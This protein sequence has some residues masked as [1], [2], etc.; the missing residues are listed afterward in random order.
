MSEIQKDALCDHVASQFG[1]NPTL[2]FNPIAGRVKVAMEDI[3]TKKDMYSVKLTETIVIDGFNPRIKDEKYWEGIR[4]L[5]ASMEKHG[6]YPDKPLAGYAI[7][8][9]GKD[10]IVV[11]EGGRRRDAGLMYIEKMSKTDE[12]FA[13]KWLAPM[14]TK[15]MGTSEL[16]LQYGLAQ[17]NNTEP[18]RPYELA[19]LCKRL[20][21]VFDQTEKQIVEGMQGLVSAS[22]LPKLLLLASA[23]LEIVE[24]VESGSMSVT[25]SYDLMMA[26]GDKAV[27][28]LKQAALVSKAAGAKKIMKKHM[29]GVKFA[30]ALVKES[31]PLFE[32]A[33]EIQADEG[34]QALSEGT[35]AKLDDMLREIKAMQTKF[36]EDDAKILQAARDAEAEAAGQTSLDMAGADNDEN[37]GAQQVA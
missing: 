31:R 6:W 29:P 11:V 5:A 27:E 14:V 37:L 28:V 22:H 26:H 7:K 9:D 4:A 34:Y 36:A 2:R 17:G 20:H 21:V 33:E 8:K 25:E 23:P 35:R 13:D 15:K 32:M 1:L 12:H 10:V 18:F 3:G 24:A 30:K 16:D 19:I